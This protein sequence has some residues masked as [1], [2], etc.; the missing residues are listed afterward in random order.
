MLDPEDRM[1]CLTRA[2]AHLAAGGRLALDSAHGGY[3]GSPLDERPR[4]MLIVA[5]RRERS[6]RERRRA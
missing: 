2:R 6:G 5:T 3:D 1:A 4:K